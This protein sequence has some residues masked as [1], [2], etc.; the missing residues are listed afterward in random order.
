MIGI[1]SLPIAASG[2]DPD[3]HDASLDSIDLRAVNPPA[4]VDISVL[5]AKTSQSINSRPEQLSI[6]SQL[7]AYLAL[8]DQCR[9][10]TDTGNLALYTVGEVRGEPGDNKVRM[11]WEARARLATTQTFSATLCT[12][13][14]AP[15]NLS[16]EQAQ[17]DSEFVERLVDDGVS[18][19]LIVL[20]AHGGFIEQYTD[21]QA[22]HVQ[23]LLADKGA[24]S[25]ICK[26]YKQG[27]GAWDRWHISSNN[28][29]RRSFPGLD[30]A[31]SRKF[32][33]AVSFHGMTHDVVL[34]G[35]GAEY[36][37]KQA[38]HAAI[39]SVLAGSGIEVSIAG[40]DDLY[41]GDSADNVVN[42]LTVG[43]LGGVH[44]EQSLRARATYGL[45][46]ATA[47]ADVF[48]DLIPI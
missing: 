23:T 3:T 33:Y 1:A 22:A 19:S 31:A 47:V 30:Q 2:C 39:A 28:I 24:S 37:L 44:I 13:V 41:N 14:V 17:L 20:A 32:A 7:A 26:G 4:D 8:G 34:I 45:A 5:Q 21:V 36:W 38:V 16:D 9:V 35:G 12:T 42:W 43:G 40:P 11:G 10:V 6:D 46:I 48:Y 25:W 29:S 15:N 18:T 27:G